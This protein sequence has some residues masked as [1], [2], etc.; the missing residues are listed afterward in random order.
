MVLIW[1]SRFLVSL[2]AC[3]WSSVPLSDRSCTGVLALLIHNG[4]FLHD[5]SWPSANEPRIFL[6]KTLDFN[7]HLVQVIL[8]ATSMPL[9]GAAWYDRVR[10]FVSV[11]S[12]DESWTSAGEPMMTRRS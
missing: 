1:V 12:R 7:N 9:K 2:R 11:L 5:E 6:T 10:K 8:V 4:V 3:S